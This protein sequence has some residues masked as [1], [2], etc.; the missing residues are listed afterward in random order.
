MNWPVYKKYLKDCHERNLDEVA[1]L[2]LNNKPDCYMQG[3]ASDL[4]VLRAAADL[5]RSFSFCKNV[6]WLVL[7]IFWVQTS[8]SSS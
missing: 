5:V 6:L 2:I 4:K 8:S 7:V 3:I 1:A